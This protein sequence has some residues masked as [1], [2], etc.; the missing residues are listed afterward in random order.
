MVVGLTDAIDLVNGVFF[1]I[2]APA[3]KAL[4]M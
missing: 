1:L 3:P 4:A 2:I